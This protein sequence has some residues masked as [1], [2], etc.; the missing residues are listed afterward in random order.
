M[1]SILL[2]QMG[3]LVSRVYLNNVSDI[4]SIIMAPMGQLVSRFNPNHGSDVAY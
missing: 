3:L 4:V 2:S 1:D